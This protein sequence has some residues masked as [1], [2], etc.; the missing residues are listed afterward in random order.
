MTVST[1][2]HG[3]SRWQLDGVDL[4]GLYRTVAGNVA[5]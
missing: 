3:G 1:T 5:Q 4:A 2:V